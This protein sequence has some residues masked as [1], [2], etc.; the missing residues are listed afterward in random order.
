VGEALGTLVFEE[1]EHVILTSATLT[2][3]G[4]FEFIKS[5]LGLKYCEELMLGSPFNYKEQALLYLRDTLSDPGQRHEEYITSLTKE[6]ESLLEITGGRAFVLF[7]SYQ[8]MDRVYSELSCKLNKY[9]IF[10]QGDMPAYRL[11]EEFKEKDGSVLFGTA[12]FWQGVDVPGSALECVIIARLP[13]SVPGEPVIEARLEEIRRRGKN[14]FLEYQVPQAILRLKQGFGRLIR[15]K[16]D[17][18]VV[19]ILDPRI[20][21][22]DYGRMFLTSLPPCRHTHILKDVETFLAKSRARL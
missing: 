7:T 5:R 6:I 1:I 21:T 17:T 4:N 14:P 11:L 13:F 10:R 20:K 22:R 8:D 18:G 12:T 9:H 19:A 16:D 15:R 3:Q 2:T